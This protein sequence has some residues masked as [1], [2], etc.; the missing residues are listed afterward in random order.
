MFHLGGR[1]TA[2][3]WQRPYKMEARADRPVASAGD[4]NF[5]NWW[6]DKHSFHDVPTYFPLNSSVIY[7]NIDHYVEE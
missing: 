2:I 3:I 6:D 7:N 1:I 5:V 4:K